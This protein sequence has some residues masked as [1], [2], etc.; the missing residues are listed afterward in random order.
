VENR[1]WLSEVKKEGYF[2]PG[3]SSVLW[4]EHAFFLDERATT[5][6]VRQYF[7]S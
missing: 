4:L 6:T 1:Y 5:E 7:E 3:T 2:I